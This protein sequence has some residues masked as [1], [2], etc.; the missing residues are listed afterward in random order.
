MLRPGGLEKVLDTVAKHYTL[1][2]FLG[3]EAAHSFA[4]QERKTCFISSLYTMEGLDAS[5]AL[6]PQSLSAIP[7][8]VGGEM[9]CACVYA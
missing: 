4:V 8:K 3:G 6:S 5:L 2:H 7:Q 9:A 1:S